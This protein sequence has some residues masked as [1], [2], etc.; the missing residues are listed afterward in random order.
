MQQVKKIIEKIVTKKETYKLLIL[1]V[2]SFIFSFSLFFITSSTKYI[3]SLVLFILL[4]GFYFEY[5]HLLINNKN[6]QLPSCKNIFKT[7][8]T[9]LKPIIASCLLFIISLLP[10]FLI[11]I[12]LIT[13]NIS[14]NVIFILLSFY[15][16]TIE[17]IF[18]RYIGR[19]SLIYAE[20]LKLLDF[21]NLKKAQNHVN[22]IKLEKSF[23]NQYLNH[24]Q[25]QIS[26][27]P[28]EKVL[29]TLSWLSLFCIIL[30]II[31]LHFPIQSKT[32]LILINL[33]CS[34]IIAIVMTLMPLSI[35]KNIQ[36]YHSL[37][38]K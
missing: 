31:C 22:A 2:I 11:T 17:L 15:I 5:A 1:F 25:K 28:I 4:M 38:K 35:N 37:C 16:I 26:K 3:S 18:F 8:I 9:G 19:L 24:K 12:Y 23:F 20:S 10:I 7:F 30:Y 34:T 27:S 14:K 32:L 33:F 6:A 13:F 29:I 21:I 36:L